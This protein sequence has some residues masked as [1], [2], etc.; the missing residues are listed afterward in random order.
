[1]DKKTIFVFN[2]VIINELGQILVENRCEKELPDADQKWGLPGGKI[3]YGETPEEAVIRE[4]M[5]ETGYAVEILGMIPIT[6][7]SI[8]HYANK[9]LHTVIIGYYG[10]LAGVAK[11]KVQDKK[12][13][14]VKW[15]TP[16]EVEKLELLP[17][18]AE[19]IEYTLNYYN[20]CR[21]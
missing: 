19:M 8:W 1:M 11:R 18:V 14:Y 20:D 4:T 5:E 17:G 9:E 10:K 16:Q 21:I 15:V 7:T 6:Y 2:G 3:E 12:V 13:N